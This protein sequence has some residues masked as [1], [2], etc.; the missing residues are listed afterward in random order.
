MTYLNY[1]TKFSKA[2]NYL[3]V[4]HP[5]SI[6][7]IAFNVMTMGFYEKFGTIPLFTGA[8]VIFKLPI[9]RRMLAWWGGTPVS[10]AAMKKNLVR[11]HPYNALTLWPGGVQEMFYGLDQEQIIL[12]K[13]K[14]FAKIALQTGASLVP[15][16]TFGAN[17]VWTRLFD[18]D[19]FAARLSSRLQTS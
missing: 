8:D 17:E 1:R 19:S 13:R 7:G 11:P 5:H 9:V 2:K 3:L 16:Y 14:G 18:A 15:V 12:S 4:Y 10:G 6:F